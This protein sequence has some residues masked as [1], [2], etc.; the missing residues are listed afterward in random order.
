[1]A[2]ARWMLRKTATGTTL[3]QKDGGAPPEVVIDPQVY[4]QVFEASFPDVKLE[5]GMGDFELLVVSSGMASRVA[6]V[7]AYTLPDQDRVGDAASVH[8]TAHRSGTEARIVSDQNFGQEVLEAVQVPGAPAV[9]VE[10]LGAEEVQAPSTVAA[11]PAEAPTAQ[12]A[13]S[14]HD[15]ADFQML[16]GVVAAK[17]LLKDPTWA[18]RCRCLPAAAAS[19]CQERRATTGVNPDSALYARTYVGANSRE[20]ERVGVEVFTYAPKCKTAAYLRL[21]QAYQQLEYLPPT[22]EG[23]ALSLQMVHDAHLLYLIETANLGG[24]ALSPDNVVFDAAVEAEMQAR[25]DFIAAKDAEY[26]QAIRRHGIPGALVRLWDKLSR[27]TNLK[28][29][30]YSDD[31]GAPKFESMADSLKD[32][33]GYALILAGLYQEALEAENHNSAVCTPDQGE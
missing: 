32:L 22:E 21:F 28:A 24:E 4:K 3:W 31:F 16:V 20:V 12:P 14:P 6:S 25:A 11:P 18:E 27:Y 7:A 1:M 23:Y 26:G 33:G 15:P 9:R 29:Q 5:Y 19:A 2:Y 8:L 30:S 10:H 17:I 13:A